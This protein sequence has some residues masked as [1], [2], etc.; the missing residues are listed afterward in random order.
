[1]YVHTKQTGFTLVETL[2]SITILL[3]VI[4]GPMSISSSTARSTSFSSEQVVAF[5]LAQEGAELAQKAR[6]DLWLDDFSNASNG[7]TAFT[8]EFGTYADCYSTTGSGCGLELLDT[9]AVGGLKTPTACSTT[10]DCKL[11]YNDAGDRARYTYNS[12]GAT[13]TPYTRIIKLENINPREVKVTSRV[14]WRS[15][16]QRATQEAVV[17]TYLFKI[18]GS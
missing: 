10:A 16:N 17:E 13:T 2:V 18:Y 11:H 12:S 8:D 6:D 5:F 3:I 9:S 1:M 15:G 14:Y 7:W 4:V